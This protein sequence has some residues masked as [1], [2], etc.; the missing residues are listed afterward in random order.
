MG[1]LDTC[2]QVGLISNRLLLTSFHFKGLH[3]G[4]N[5]ILL[6]SQ[7][8]VVNIRMILGNN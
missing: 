7:K 4:M 1:F 2:T 8:I 6:S 3:L 5:K